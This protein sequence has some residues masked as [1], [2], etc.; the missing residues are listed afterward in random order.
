VKRREC[1]LAGTYQMY[2]CYQKQCA[3][4]LLRVLHIRLVVAYPSQRSHSAL[5]CRL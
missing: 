5:Q 3:L 4:V 2:F 1:R